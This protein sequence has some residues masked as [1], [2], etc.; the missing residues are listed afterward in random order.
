MQSYAEL[1]PPS[2]VTHAVRSHFTGAD[3]NNLIVARTSVLQVFSLKQTIGSQDTKLVLVAEERLAGTITSLGSVKTLESKSGGEA[4]LIAFR[5]AKLSLV[6]WDPYQYC[7][8]TIS[9]HYY[10]NDDFLRCP[11][12]PDLRD[13][14]SRLAIDPSSRCAALNFGI[15]NLAVIPFHQTQDDLIMDDFEEVEQQGQNG[16]TYKHSKNMSTH[17][18]PYASS[19][20]LPLTAL[21]SSILHPV[22]FAFLYEYRE[23]T[24]GVLFSTSARSANLLPERKDVLTYAVYTLDLEQKASINLMVIPRLPNDLHSVVAL[25]LPV[26]GTLLVGSN[27]VVHVDQGGKSTAIGVN[28]FARQLSSFSMA[29]RS[30]LGMKLE[31]CKVQDTGN[32]AGD[33]ILLLASGELVL[34]EFRLDGRSVS[35]MSLQRILSKSRSDTV[36]GTFSCSANL[37]LGKFFIGSEEGD[38]VL[39]GTAKKT[40]QLRRQSSRGMTSMD[41]DA[42]EIRDG[43]SE[44]EGE[45]NADDDDDLYG[46]TSNQAV[47]GGDF[48]SNH[49]SGANL[50]ILDR[51]PCLGPMRD[52]TFGRHAKRKRENDDTKNFAIGPDLELAIASGR[53]SSGGIS[54]FSRELS[55]QVI[56][57]EKYDNL[58]GVW[59]FPVKRFKKENQRDHHTFDDHVIL[60]TRKPDGAGE[61]ALYNISDGILTE[62]EGTEFDV[63]AGAT[64]EIGNLRGGNHTIQVLENE[65]RVYD[66]GRLRDILRLH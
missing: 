30:D 11:W 27:E 66:L 10:E 40:S 7:I 17:A 1:V 13:C 14:P 57:R 58:T 21:D 62:K 24:I 19:F 55:P 50:R 31:G 18:V 44:A 26:G 54:L 48:Q 38:S 39:I 60:S 49:I 25:P 9:I 45:S 52:V 4:L 37:D 56:S 23:P 46:E 2:G 20:V 61:S 28:E 12:A 63:S 43:V 36:Q 64:I 29:D 51:L 65:V 32:E 34:L 16:S 15:G 35:S 41:T 22:E 47:N 8:S 5:D 53:G 3:S 33:M 59:S 6:E 42:N